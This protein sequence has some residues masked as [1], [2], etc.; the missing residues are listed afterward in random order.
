MEDTN[1]VVNMAKK[2]IEK[3][4]KPSTQVDLPPKLREYPNPREEK[5]AFA[6]IWELV[7]QTQFEL[8]GS[9]LASRV[10]EH[11]PRVAMSIIKEGHECV[12]Q[13]PMSFWEIARKLEQE[14]IQES[15][16]LELVVIVPNN[17]LH[18]KLT[19][20]LNDIAT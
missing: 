2:A 14:P 19:P 7:K 8:K 13:T 6:T 10:I 9:M 18:I 20:M 12:S 1:E 11:T 4:W 5:Q 3:Q 16:I 17:Q 15:Q